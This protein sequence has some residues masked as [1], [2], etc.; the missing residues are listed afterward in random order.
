MWRLRRRISPSKVRQQ[1]PN[2]LHR[3][4]RGKS[5]PTYFG[6]LE[7]IPPIRPRPVVGE[8]LWPLE[9]MEGTGRSADVALA[10]DLPGESCDRARYL[11]DLGEHYHAGEFRV[12]T[13]RD[14]RVRDEDSHHLA[15]GGLDVFVE[16]FDEHCG[17]GLATAMVGTLEGVNVCNADTAGLVIHTFV[18]EYRLTGYV[19]G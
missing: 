18:G 6:D 9:A 12:R 19:T 5:H 8:W 1:P 16:L 17:D 11:V 7:L 13:V 3:E 15:R 14:R 10:G 4:T 2:Q